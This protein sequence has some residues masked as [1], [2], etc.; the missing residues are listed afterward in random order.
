[1]PRSTLAVTSVNSFLC[2][3]STYLRIGSK[4][5]CIRSTPTALSLVRN[6]WWR[7]I[8]TDA[9]QGTNPLPREGQRSRPSLGVYLLKVATNSKCSWLRLE[10]V[11]TYIKHC[12]DALISQWYGTYTFARRRRNPSPL[13]E[14]SVLPEVV[15]V[16]TL[17]CSR[18]RILGSLREL[19]SFTALP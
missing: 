4:F 1:M 2:Q 11:P 16:D 7:R 5:R 18:F 15:I 12:M 10:G 14:A 13:P 6:E 9:C 8:P 3:T 17:S 19:F